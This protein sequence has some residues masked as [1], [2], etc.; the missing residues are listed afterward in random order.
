MWKVCSKP[1]T[2]TFFASSGCDTNLHYTVTLNHNAQILCLPY[3]SLNHVDA[4][5]AERLDAVVDVYHSL[6]LCHVQHYIQD[7]V[8]TRPPSTH[9]AH[10]DIQK[11]RANCDY[12]FILSKYGWTCVIIIRILCHTFERVH[13]IHLINGGKSYTFVADSVIKDMFEGRT[14]NSPGQNLKTTNMQ[15]DMTCAFF[16]QFSK[17]I[18]T[19]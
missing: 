6:T 15:N 9:T 13:L 8:A 5:R 17:C 11:T 2:D 16:S 12:L 4:P 14:T 3:L 1:Q 19:L 18:I 10:T 7:N